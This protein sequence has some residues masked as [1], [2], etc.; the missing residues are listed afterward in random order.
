MKKNRLLQPFLKWAGGKRQLMPEIKKYIPHKFNTYYEPFL[1]GGAVL[2]DL[3]P[4]N[5]IINDSSTELIN[6]YKVIKTNINDLIE[7]LE[8]HKNDEDYY[9]HTRDLDRKEDYKNLS[10]VE[11]ASRIIYLNRTCFNGLFRVNSQGQF[12]VPFG[13]Y[14]NPKILNESVLKAVSSYLNENNI[15]ILNNDFE[16]VLKHAKKEDFVYLDPPY[17]PLSDTSSFTGYDLNKFGKEEQKR[18]KKVY[19]YLNEIGCFVLLSNSSTPYIKDLYKNYSII[20][21]NAKRNI[22]SVGNSRGKI[23]EILVK[24][25]E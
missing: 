3:Q 15:E 6:C 4:K 1:G 10:N 14:P 23:E 25:Y 22:N 20:T 21:V 24:N 2:F 12:N 8:K 18:L 17:D 7:D 13:K 11:K 9:Y 5:A 19:D 16:E